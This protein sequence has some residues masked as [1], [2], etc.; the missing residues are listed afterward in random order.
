MKLSKTNLSVALLM[1]G[2]S[3]AVPAQT[4]SDALANGEPLSLSVGVSGEVAEVLVSE[5][6]HVKQGQL[7]LKLNTLTYQSALNATQAALDYAKFKAQLSEEDFERQ[8][9]LYDEGSLSTVELQQLELGLKLA[10]SELANARSAYHTAKHDLS[11]AKIIA[12]IDGEVLAVP[13]VGQRVNV[14]VSGVLVKIK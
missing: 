10:Q 1:M 14:D 5:G 7:L 8:Q 13:L 9:A 3:M 11:R 4:L 12:P 6:E 2:A